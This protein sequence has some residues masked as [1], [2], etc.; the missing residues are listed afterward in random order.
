MKRAVILMILCTSFSTHAMPASESS[1]TDV[2]AG[3]HVMPPGSSML[4][5][6]DTARDV[7]N[8]TGRHPDWLRIPAGSSEILTFAT[9]P[10]RAD[11]AP[12]LIISE[13]DKPMSDW[14][15]AVA[16]QA[17]GEGFIALVPD[18]LTG[19]SQT[20]RVEAVRR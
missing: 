7:L 19:L 13:K 18:S 3:G 10:D 6:R 20:A 15:R 12:V 1:A 2:H 17:A 4:P 5:S 16:D 11:K 8:A 9:Y 14:M